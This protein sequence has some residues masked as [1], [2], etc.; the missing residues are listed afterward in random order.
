MKHLKSFLFITVPVLLVFLLLLELIFRFVLPASDPPHYYYDAPEQIFK[1]D[2][3]ERQGRITFGPLAAMPARWQIN[4]DG[5]NSAIEYKE[6]KT[7][8]KIRIAIIGDSYVEALQV[9]TDASF[10]ALL[11]AQLGHDYEVFSFG[12]SAAPLSQYLHLSRYVHRHYHPD[13]LV[14][15]LVHNDF[16]ASLHHSQMKGWPYLAIKVQQDSSLSE[17]M[18]PWDEAV[19]QYERR[20]H[21]IYKSALV[22]YLFLNL[23]LK[24]VLANLRPGTEQNYVANIIV[25]KVNAKKGAIVRVTDYLLCKLQ[26]ENQD[27]III[28]MMDGLRDE[29][30]SG[31]D[32]SQNPIFWLEELVQQ[33]CQAYG[34][35]FLPLAAAF[36]QDY[37]QHHTKFN[38]DQDGHW[39]RYGHQ[40]VAA[41]LHECMKPLLFDK[42]QNH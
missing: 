33:K 40:V 36:S 1:L 3:Q 12:T 19:W 34:L 29:L 16:L 9:D 28:V 11:R 31:K 13:V 22:R 15:N 24:H 23:S 27:K 32:F 21:V 18:T 35:H 5:W 10:P 8:G 38:F 30:Y 7:P 41:A 42:K 25:N 2:T 6:E 20:K 14:I 37:R 39:N 26:E 4:R 17:I